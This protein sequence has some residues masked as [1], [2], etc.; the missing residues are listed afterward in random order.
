MT[1]RLSYTVK[2]AAQSLGISVPGLY[3]AIK[4][5][6][7]ECVKFGGRTLIRHTALEAALDAAPKGVLKRPAPSPPRSTAQTPWPPGVLSGRGKHSK[8]P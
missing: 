1:E 7:V 6:R 8:L 2:E 4:A 5:G 3:N